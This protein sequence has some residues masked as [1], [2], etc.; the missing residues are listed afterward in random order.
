MGDMNMSGI[1]PKKLIVFFL[2]LVISLI[3]KLLKNESEQLQQG[4]FNR[5]TSWLFK[6]FILGLIVVPLA[7]VAL[8]FHDHGRLIMITWIP[9]ALIPSLLA[10]SRFE[11]NI[12][13]PLLKSSAERSNSNKGKENQSH[14]K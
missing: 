6:G 4:G 5:E 14:E 12:P 9:F 11:R 1:N 7:V 13:L 8:T 2:S 10:H 3:L